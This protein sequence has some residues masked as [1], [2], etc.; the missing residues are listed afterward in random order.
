MNLINISNLHYRK[1]NFT[2]SIKN[3][4]NIFNKNY[5][6]DQTHMIENVYIFETLMQ[7]NVFIENILTSFSMILQNVFVFV[8]STND[9][10][11]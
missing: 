1:F 7:T 3:F 4:C 9:L 8:K 10:Q 2:Y 6:V 11:I 5:F